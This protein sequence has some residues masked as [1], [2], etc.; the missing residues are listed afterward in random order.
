LV[1]RAYPAAGLP[2]SYGPAFRS[3]TCVAAPEKE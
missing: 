3:G 1:E 2:C